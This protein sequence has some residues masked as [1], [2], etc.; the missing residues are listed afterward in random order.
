MSTNGGPPAPAYAGL[1]TRVLAFAIDAVIVNVVAWVTAALIAVGLSLFVLPQG[2]KVVLA[3]I[4]AGIA[5]IWFVAYFAVF[6]SATGQTPGDRVMRIRVLRAT[7]EPP[8]AL[9][10][11]V[12]VFALLLSALPLCAGFLM[13]L[14]DDRRRALH[15]RIVG[16]VVVYTPG[17]R[18]PR[19][20]PARAIAA[21]E[22]MRE[23][24]H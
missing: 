2:V 12:R 18:P 21:P 7:G 22:P 8:H 9:R 24:Y 16:T 4:G 11:L 6:W 13:I 20:T 5:L 14:V 19:R 10:A 17:G 23:V 15:D 3:A 1:A